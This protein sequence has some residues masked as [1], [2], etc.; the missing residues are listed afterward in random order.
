[1]G[2]GK[3]LKTAAA[4]AGAAATVAGSL[5]G[6]PLSEQAARHLDV[7]QQKRQTYALNDAN[8]RK[9]PASQR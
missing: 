1:M 8:K 4:A 9:P 5:N 6:M 2:I 7:Q 3:K